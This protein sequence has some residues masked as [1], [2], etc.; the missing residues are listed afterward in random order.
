MVIPPGYTEEEV[1]REIESVVRVLA[2]PFKFGCYGVDDMQQEG[3][4]FALEALPSYDPARGSLKVFLT[5][6]IRNR[7]INLKRDKFERK[8]APCDVCP[9]CVKQGDQCKAFACKDECDKWTGWQKRNQ[10]KKTLMGGS[11]SSAVVENSPDT[12]E[13][14][15]P[16]HHLE[17]LHN[18]EVIQYVD[19]NIPV[20]M[21]ADY[22]RLLHGVKL[23][24]VRRDKI[25]EFIRKLVRDKY[26][27]EWQ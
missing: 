18:Q 13:E 6:H 7:F 5:R 19:S 3:R 14:V 4:L 22:C 23:S 2:P 12:S 1:L 26:G 15:V 11:L 25:V 9:F 16:S 24:K 8:R 17:Q 21:R 27:D 10:V 20:N